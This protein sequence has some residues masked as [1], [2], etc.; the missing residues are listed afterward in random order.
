MENKAMNAHLVLRFRILQNDEYDDAF[1]Y[2]FIYEKL[3]EFIQELNSSEHKIFFKNVN[4]D[5]FSDFPSFDD[6]NTSSEE[7]PEEVS[8]EV[9]EEEDDD[10]D[11]D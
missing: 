1:C 6:S 7:V 8:E 4:V 11:G 2:N 10:D 9:P 3:S 5:I